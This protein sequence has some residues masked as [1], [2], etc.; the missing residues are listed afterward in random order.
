MAVERR[1]AVVYWPADNIWRVTDRFEHAHTC[2]Q[3]KGNPEDCNQLLPLLHTPKKQHTSDRIPAMHLSLLHFPCLDPGRVAVTLALKRK[4][5]EPARPRW[6]RIERASR[7]KSRWCAIKLQ[8]SFCILYIICTLHCLCCLLSTAPQQKMAKKHTP[9]Q[10]F[11]RTALVHNQGTFLSFPLH[12]HCCQSALQNQTLA[13]NR[14][15]YSASG[16]KKKKATKCIVHSRSGGNMNNGN[17]SKSFHCQS[18]AMM[19]WSMTC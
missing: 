2:A 6:S 5:R 14:T 3:G 16:I 19:T 1:G 13:T 18:V 10:R 11:L 12:C 9:P 17:A 15:N 4:W 7:K 8:M